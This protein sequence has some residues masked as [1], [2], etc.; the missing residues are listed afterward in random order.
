MHGA[1]SGGAGLGDSGCACV[2]GC[3][4]FSQMD[5]QVSHL[6]VSSGKILWW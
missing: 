5:W 3:V 1:L 4:V 2:F 6:T